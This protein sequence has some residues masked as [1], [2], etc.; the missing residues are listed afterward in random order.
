MLNGLEGQWPRDRIQPEKLKKFL[1][2]SAENQGIEWFPHEEKTLDNHQD[3]LT[4]N[5]S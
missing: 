2:T 1:L 4:K 3:R 5:I